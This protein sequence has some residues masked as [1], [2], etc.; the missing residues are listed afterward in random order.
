VN[1][2]KFFILIGLLLL[3]GALL[4]TS[5][6]IAQGGPPSENGTTLDEPVFNKNIAPDKATPSFFRGIKPKTGILDIAVSDDYESDSDVAFGNNVYGIAYERG[7]HIYVAFFNISGHFLSQDQVSIGPANHSNPAIAFEGTSNLFVVA[8]E[9]NVGG[10]DIDIYARAVSA[11]S[12]SVGLE[13]YLAIS[14]YS[15][16]EPDLDC[17]HDDTSCLVVFSYS[18]TTSKYIKGR[19]VNVSSLGIGPIGD[20]PFRVSAINNMV[21]PHIAWGWKN[22]RYM[23][24]YHYTPSSGDDV[25]VYTHVYDTYQSSGNQ[26]IFGCT[27]LINPGTGPNELPNDIFVTGITYDPVSE[28]FLTLVTYDYYGDGSD[29]D[30][31]LLVNS[32]SEKL[33][34]TPDR[35][36]ANW[37]ADETLGSISFLTSAWS[38]QSG[39]GPDKVAVA[40]LRE[41]TTTE[42]VTT[43]I[44]GNGSK[45]NPVYEIPEE[46]DHVLVKGA[47]GIFGSFVTDPA[48]AG[49][50]GSGLYMVT[51]TDHIPGFAADDE[52]IKGMIFQDSDNNVFLPL[53][54]K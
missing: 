47:S 31:L 1:R 50:D 15:E 49:S 28:K 54:L 11:F 14:D 3:S 5:N 10:G 29:M 8:Y 44:T 40:Y 25:S 18:S 22:G 19:F 37:S 20:N 33:R 39:T 2:K 38:A 51:L 17:N 52:D 30:L 24:V 34:H 23:V 41:L 48:A 32:A 6:V 12:G 7:G 43:V 35:V 46:V 9:Y 4:L 13:K 26:N 16:T 36:I 45:T 53:I 42:I 21:N 27:Y